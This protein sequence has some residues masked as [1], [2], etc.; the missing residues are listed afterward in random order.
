MTTINKSSKDYKIIIGQKK[1]VGLLQSN[2]FILQLVSTLISSL[3]FTILHY[4]VFC[5]AWFCFGYLG[6]GDNGLIKRNFI[7]M[8]KNTFCLLCGP[9]P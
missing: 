3:T 6:V 8:D 9:P 1:T 4:S 7:H 5:F 2:E